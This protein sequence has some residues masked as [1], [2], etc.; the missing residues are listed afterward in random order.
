MTTTDPITHHVA[1]L[2]RAL[3][4]PQRACRGMIAEARAGLLDAADAYRAGG[5]SPEQAAAN[6]VRDFGTVREVA[7]LF[8][9]ELTARQ[10]RQAAMLFAIVF[11][12]MLVGWDLLW[13]NGFV[14]RGPAPTELV[15][16]LSGLLDTMSVFIAATALALLAVTFLRSVPPRWVT[17]AVGLTGTT[18]AILCG[19]TSIAMNVAGGRST[20]EVLT[21][22]PLAAVALVGSGAVLALLVWQSVR[23]L[24]VCSAH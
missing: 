18:G 16:V 19:G 23:T 17:M 9:D 22:N 11:P 6:A 20:T 15:R 13:S 21:A 3:R 12:T 8:Q 10:G 5:L 24:R 1:A 4:G 2:E 7:P 14:R